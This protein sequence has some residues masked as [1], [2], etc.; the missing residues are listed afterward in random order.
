[1]LSKRAGAATLR[2]IRA[3]VQVATLRVIRAGVQ[4]ATL[5]DPKCSSS[6]KN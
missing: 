3:G 1:M 5:R 4:V 2:V 6:L